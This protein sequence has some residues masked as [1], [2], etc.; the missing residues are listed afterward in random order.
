[1]PILKCLPFLKKRESD[2]SRDFEEENEF[3]KN[4]VGKKGGLSVVF[5]VMFIIGE[6]AG[7]GILALPRFVSIFSVEISSGVFS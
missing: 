5:A 1:M 4:G 7:S 3:I 6:M 2:G